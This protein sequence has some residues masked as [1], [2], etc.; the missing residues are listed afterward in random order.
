[1]VMDP[2]VH[3]CRS[4]VASPQVAATASS[5]SVSAFASESA[6]AS[7][8]VSAFASASVSAF[9]L[10]SVSA[11]ASASVSAFASALVSAFA[12]ACLGAGLKLL[13][14]V[15]QISWAPGSGGYWSSFSFHCR[16]DVHIDL[17][18]CCDVLVGRLGLCGAMCHNGPRV[19][20]C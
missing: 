1:M 19:V 20:Y 12:S 6:F 7:A 5:A 4:V 3:W 18:W 8:S 15:G 10:A 16:P 17:C 9:A 13:E 14:L 11:F 2:I